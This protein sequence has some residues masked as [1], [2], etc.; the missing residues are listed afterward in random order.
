MNMASLENCKLHLSNQDLE[1]TFLNSADNKL[2]TFYCESLKSSAAIDEMLCD[3]LESR[4]VRDVE[5]WGIDLGRRS[6]TL[7]LDF[8]YI[9]RLELGEVTMEDSTLRTLVGSVLK[10]K[11]TVTVDIWDCNISP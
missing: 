8:V 6:L 3:L 1:L 10:L 7:T 5:L 4:H 2:N 9:E 11:Q